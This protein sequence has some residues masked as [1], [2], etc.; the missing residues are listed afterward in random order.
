MNDRNPQDSKRLLA[1]SGAA[2]AA[3]MLSAC[4]APV[5][6]TSRVIEGPVDVPMAY[7]SYVQYGTVTRIEEIDTRVGDSGGGAALGAVIGGVLGN[8]VGHGSGRAAATALGIFGG[9]VVGDNVERNNAAAATH[10]TYR[11]FVRFDDGSARSFDYRGLNGLHSG[12]RVRLDHGRLD[13]A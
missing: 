5:T 10:V 6:R 9:A 1:V 2:L 12:E 11:V 4:A 13:R 3:L 7:T 8:T